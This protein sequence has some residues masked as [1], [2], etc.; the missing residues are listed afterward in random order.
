MKQIFTLSISILLFFSFVDN[1]II[2][3]NINKYIEKDYYKNNENRFYITSNLDILKSNKYYKENLSNYIAE[4]NNFYPTNKQELL[5][6]YYTI[7]NNGW[8]KFSFHCSARYKNCLNDI[9]N[10]SSNNTEFSNINQLISPFNSF[11]SILSNYVNG[12]ID[13]NVSNKYT[14]KEIDRVEEKINEIIDNLGINNIKSIREKIKV[15]HDYIANTNVYDKDKENNLSPYNSDTA[16]GT[17]FEG[18]SVCSG[19]TDT[20]AIFLDKINVTN[21]KVSNEEHTWNAILLDDTWYHLDLTWDD[22]ITNTSENIIQYEYFMITT[23]ELKAK[24]DNEH[25]YDEN[26]FNF[27]N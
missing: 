11:K 6:T 20:I 7:L 23:S 3:N 26:I 15:F 10:M 19:Y 12:R 21:V 8:N 2:A 16:I 22:P 5:N 17:L 1:N 4:T 13:V 24:N 18:H 27:I 9:E 25:N 14:D